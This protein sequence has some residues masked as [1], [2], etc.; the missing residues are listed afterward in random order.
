MRR[1]DPRVDIDSSDVG[2]NME[3]NHDGFQETSL[4]KYMNWEEESQ[5]LYGLNQDVAEHIFLWTEALSPKDCC[6]DFGGLPILTPT[7][8]LL[9]DFMYPPKG[10]IGRGYHTRR[11]ST[12][13]EPSRDLLKHVRNQPYFFLFIDFLFLEFGVEKSNLPKDGYQIA[14]LF[15]MA[16]P[17]QICES[18]LQAVKLHRKTEAV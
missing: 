16:T 8:K 7:G 4:T 18:A 9:T 11:W 15:M 5:Y 3:S 6:G 1:R 13:P 17:R 12:D 14:Y 2:R 10:I